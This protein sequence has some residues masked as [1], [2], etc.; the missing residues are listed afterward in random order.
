MQLQLALLAEAAGILSDGG[1]SIYGGDFDSLTVAQLPAIAP[2]ICVVLKLVFSPD[3]EID[4]HQVGLEITR[5]DGRRSALGDK[6]TPIKTLRNPVD[7][8]HRSP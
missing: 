6:L 3:E 5:P 8:S 7:E 2:P 1:L 4:G